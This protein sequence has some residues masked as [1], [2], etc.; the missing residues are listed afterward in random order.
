[1]GFAE[2]LADDGKLAGR[3]AAPAR[4][5]LRRYDLLRR[6][7]SHA[8]LSHP[9]L[10][11]SDGAGARRCGARALAIA[12]VQWRYMDTPPL[13]A[14]AKVVIGGALVLATGILIGSS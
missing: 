3:R 8:A 9:E 13:S 6:D 4:G 1:M 7:R 10:L 14:A 5:C 11:Y 2:A 12:W